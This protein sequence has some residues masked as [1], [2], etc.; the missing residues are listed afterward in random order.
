M[1]RPEGDE[2][3]QQVS[4]RGDKTAL[5]RTITEARKTV[6][7]QILALTDIDAKAIKILKVNVMV[8][9]A[10]LS[11]LTFGASSSSVVVSDFWNAYFGVGFVSLLV[12][13]TTAAL[14]YRATD[15]RVGVD[16]KNVQQV[17]ENDLR[18][19]E[20]LR[21]LTRSYAGWID[22]N[23]GANVRN[24]PWITSTVLAL[25][26]ALVYLSLAV[27]HTVV[28]TVSP[29]LLITTNLVLLGV[30][31]LSGLPSLVQQYFERQS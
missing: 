12:S 19:E 13:S 8:L 24:A 14:T 25:V 20:L 4:F 6:G 2:R 1:T 9:G 21:V 29:V 23:V 28:A 10:L 17:L 3:R 26:V 31:Y 5:E 16:S 22:Y 18:D 7:H 15:F 11:G 30:V 27:Y